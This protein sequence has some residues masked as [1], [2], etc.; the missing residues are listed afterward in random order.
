LR[1]PPDIQVSSI[2]Y[3]LGYALRQ[4]SVIQE[5]TEARPEEIVAQTV[6]YQ[7]ID[8]GPGG[9]LHLYVSQLPALCLHIENE[10]FRGVPGTGVVGKPPRGRE[11]TA[12]LWYV[13]LP[14]QSEGADMHGYTKGGRWTSLIWWRIKHWLSVQQLPGVG[15]GPVFDFQAVS[16]IRTLELDGSSDRFAFDSVEGIKIPLKV[17]HGATPY[18]EADPTVL[19][20]ISIGI[21]S[22]AGTGVGVDADVDV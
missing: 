17:W 7:P 20:M 22:E 3:Y 10:R 21:T 18:E 9:K 14:F 15:T 2:L 6:E 12:W 19:E 4:D 11:F 13:F 1:A 5:H 16:N 8:R